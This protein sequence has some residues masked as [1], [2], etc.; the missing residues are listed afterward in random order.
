MCVC[1]CV[2]VCVCLCVCV[3]VKCFAVVLSGTPEVC[4]SSLDKPSNFFLFWI[5]ERFFMQNILS[6]PHT[7]LLYSFAILPIYPLVSSSYFVDAT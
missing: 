3:S 6:I 4:P 7:H 2:C 5:E 1:V